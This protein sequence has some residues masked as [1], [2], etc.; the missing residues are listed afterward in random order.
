MVLS[1]LNNVKISPMKGDGAACFMGRI[2]RHIT[3]HR[4]LHLC[5]QRGARLDIDQSIHGPTATPR[6]M[7]VII[8]V[9]LLFKAPDIHLRSLEKIWVDSVVHDRP[10][11]EFAKQLRND[12]QEF[13]L[14]A[15]V[16]LGANMSFLAIQSVDNGGN[17]VRDRSAA[18]IS[19]YISIVT[20][21]GTVIF[22]LL[23]SR[24]N[25]SMATVDD[26][27]RFLGKMTHKTRGLEGLAILYALPY[28]LLMWSALTFLAA[29]SFTCFRYSSLATRIPVAAVL[30]SLFMFI[31]WC[32]VAAWI[33]RHNEG[34]RL[35]S[36]WR[37]NLWAYR[38][39]GNSQ[40]GSEE[41]LT[42]AGSP[43]GSV[44]G[45]ERPE[46]KRRWGLTPRFFIHKATLDQNP[47][48]LGLQPV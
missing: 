20:C 4:F 45:G 8:F 29:F 18:Q 47:E 1:L 36:T 38:S 2:M 14:M 44:V 37:T 31:A 32:M 7:L 35:P 17:I 12:Y 23:L 9:S 43:S 34:E 6:P 25:R 39:R 26:A 27:A 5:G 11:D 33:T 41:G 24:Q 19:S 21:L 30:F 40:I 15:T 46:A 3:H 42:P 28:A 22:A 13:S 48:N 16:L 10:W